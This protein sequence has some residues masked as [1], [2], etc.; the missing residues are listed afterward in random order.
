MNA[1]SPVVAFR[2]LRTCVVREWCE[3]P[4]HMSDSGA[5]RIV[6]PPSAHPRLE[7]QLV[8][9]AAPNFQPRVV[10]AE[11]PKP[12]PADSEQ[13][14]SHHGALKRLAWSVQVTGKEW[15]SLVEK[16]PV[17][18]ASRTVV[19]RSILEGVIIENIDQRTH[20]GP[21]VLK[22]QKFDSKESQVWNHFFFVQKTGLL[23]P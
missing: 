15:H 9:F 11:L 20:D 22:H 12:L 16:V 2:E 4:I 5:R 1:V 14:S 8:L 6:H 19:L 21:I 17:E 18:N 13:S 7:R 3:A 23:S 10:A